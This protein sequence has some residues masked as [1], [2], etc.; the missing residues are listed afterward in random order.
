MIAPSTSTASTTRPIWP[1]RLRPIGRPL[2]NRCL[3]MNEQCLGKNFWDF[4]AKKPAH[5]TWLLRMLKRFSPDGG[6]SASDAQSQLE[7]GAVAI[8]VQDHFEYAIALV[9]METQ[10]TSQESATCD[11]IKFLLKQCSTN[12]I[13]A[14][15]AELSI[16]HLKGWT[17]HVVLRKTFHLMRWNVCRNF[18]HLKE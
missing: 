18:F 6:S 17:K 8:W 7:L 10:L 2:R 9:E 16:C 3:A 4:L 13:A 1:I 14:A 15:A 11:I 12:V 5:T